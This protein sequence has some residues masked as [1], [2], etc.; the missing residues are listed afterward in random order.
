MTIILIGILGAIISAIT[1]KYWYS[2][3]TRMG[4]IQM[5]YLGFDKLT[6]QEKDDLIAKAKPE[7]W[8]S[9]SAQMFLSFLTAT[10]I[11][12]VTSFTVQNGAP[13]SAIFFYV[14]AIWI[15]FV[16]PMIGQNLIWGNAD[17]SLVWKK[18]ISDA[19][20]NLVTFLIIAF[21]TTLFF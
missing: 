5:Q 12:L 13:A 11:A 7:M 2:N 15:A 18:F 19:S 3:S 21:L 4:K 9:Y 1:G 20:Y 8:K 17:R 10:F 6:Q 16:V 14:I